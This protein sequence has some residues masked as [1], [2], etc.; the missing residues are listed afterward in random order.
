MFAKMENNMCEQ[1]AYGIKEIAKM[2]GVDART[3]RK[4]AAECGALIKFGKAKNSKFLVIKSVFDEAI[5]T[6]YIIKE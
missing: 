2:Y 4:V 1:K 6:S 3:A 5:K